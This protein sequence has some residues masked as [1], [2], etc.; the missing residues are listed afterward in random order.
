MWDEESYIHRGYSNRKH[1]AR[2]PLRP[3]RRLEEV[4]RPAPCPDHPQ[5]VAKGRVILV[6][7]P[8]FPA[9]GQ[10][11][12]TASAGRNP[13]HLPYEPPS[14]GRS[15]SSRLAFPVPPLPPS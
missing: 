4:P 8:R 12:T 9:A 7:R 10:L 15:S 1:S 13:V 5:V 11:A 6:D 14:S 3:Y 2:L